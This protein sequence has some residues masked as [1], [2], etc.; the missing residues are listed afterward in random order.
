EECRKLQRNRSLTRTARGK[1]PNADDRQIAPV[2][3]RSLEPPLHGRAIDRGDGQKPPSGK[4]EPALIPPGWRLKPH[5]Q[6]FPLPAGR[7][8]QGR[9]EDR[10]R[11]LRGSFQARRPKYRWPPLPGA[12]SPPPLAGSRRAAS[13]QLPGRP[14]PRPAGILHSA[15]KRRRFR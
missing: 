6:S 15:A 12:S 7:E 2:G 3:R 10:V 11:A 14:G 4:R 1:V 13:K 8:K 5:V 9:E